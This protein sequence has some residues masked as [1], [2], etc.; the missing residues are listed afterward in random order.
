MSQ[1]LS[2]FFIKAD[3]QII[4]VSEIARVDLKAIEDL[5][6]TIHLKDGSV[7]IAQG[8]DA[9]EN[10]MLLKPSSLEGRRL[11]FAKRAWLIHNLIGHPLM[12]F[13]ALIGFP[14]QG[15]WVHDA[16][17]PKVLGGRK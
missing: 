11:R 2:H 13:L 15:M 14:K 17:V 9:L 12:Q 6:M 5:V 4:A 10:A 7:V 3:G 16:T 1:S 8:I